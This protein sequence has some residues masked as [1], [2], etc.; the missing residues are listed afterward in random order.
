MKLGEYAIIQKC[1]V[2]QRCNK[3]TTDSQPTKG[4]CSGSGTQTH[5][6]YLGHKIIAKVPNKKIKKVLQILNGDR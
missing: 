2:C 3:C 6:Y 5:I 4:R 1:W